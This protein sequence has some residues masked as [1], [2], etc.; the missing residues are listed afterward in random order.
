MFGSKKTEMISSSNE[1]SRMKSV[2]TFMRFLG[3]KITPRGCGA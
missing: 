1:D 3:S 2:L